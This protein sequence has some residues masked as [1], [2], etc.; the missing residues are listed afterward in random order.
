MV[1]TRLGAD[2]VAPS[3][4]DWKDVLRDRVPNKDSVTNDNC[5]GKCKRTANEREQYL[6]VVC[7]P[8]AGLSG[9]AAHVALHAVDRAVHDLVAVV[10]VDVNL[11]LVVKGL[12]TNGAVHGR[13]RGDRGQRGGASRHIVLQFLRS[14]D[15]FF[16]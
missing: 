1:V 9:P 8:F 4:N 5:I 11:E 12:A 13:V 16:V 3:K 7:Q 10:E 6:F 2:Y 15:V 14:V